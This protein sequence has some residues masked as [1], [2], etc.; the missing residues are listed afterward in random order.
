MRSSQKFWPRT[1]SV[2]G[3]VLARNH[4]HEMLKQSEVDD[5]TMRIEDPSRVV[6]SGFI[7][8][9]PQRP[10]QQSVIVQPPTVVVRS[11]RELTTKYLTH[12]KQVPGETNGSAT[13]SGSAVSQQSKQEYRPT[14]QTVGQPTNRRI[15]ASIESLDAP[16]YDTQR[17][18]G[19]TNTNSAKLSR[20][21]AKRRRKKLREGGGQT[22]D[23]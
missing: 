8:F 7:Q 6:G 13:A 14:V 22:R 21:Q 9:P 16:R 18:V 1:E 17:Q 23:I 10:F 4:A 12:D 2:A 11:T 19:G 3:A 20:A 5:A 15:Q